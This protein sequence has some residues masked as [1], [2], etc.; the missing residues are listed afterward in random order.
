MWPAELLVASMRNVQR[1]DKASARP[2]PA[3]LLRHLVWIPQE[4]GGDE[5]GGGG[6][7][8]GA[9]GEEAEAEAGAEARA[10]AGSAEARRAARR[11]EHHTVGRA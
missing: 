1:T 9:F 8:R 2:L 7:Q 5:E 4:G 3:A 6:P 10:A 11:L